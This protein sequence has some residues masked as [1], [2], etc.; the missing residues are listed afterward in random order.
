MTAAPSTSIVILTY[1]NPGILT[2]AIE[3]AL[4]LD[5]PAQE[6]I[7]VDNASTDDT[8]SVIEAQ[9]PGV[10]LIRMDVNNPVAARNTG[11]EAAESDFVVSL[12][13]DMV[14]QEADVL[15]KIVDLFKAFPDTG[16]LSFKIYGGGSTDIPLEGHWWHAR[17]FSDHNQYF[18]SRYFGEGAVAFRASAL[19]ET[20]GYDERFF[21]VEESVDL[22]L[23]FLR[24]GWQVL[25]CPV[26]VATEL[27]VSPHISTRSIRANEY[28]LRNRIWVAWKHYPLAKAI[29]Y[30]APRVVVDAARSVRF[31]WFSYYRAGLRAGLFP[32][33][34]IRQDRQPISMRQWRKLRRLEREQVDIPATMTRWAG[35]HRTPTTPQSP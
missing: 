23:R 16:V 12:D 2:R 20:G 10:K 34:S 29:A 13:H 33:A 3:S 27:V 1:N 4:A 14:L 32:P 31:R 17:P 7:V 30:V 24:L 11:Y 19:S 35:P 8:A 6:V 28:S 25:Y 21:H 9:F 22:A 15:Q 18:F 26:L 5:P